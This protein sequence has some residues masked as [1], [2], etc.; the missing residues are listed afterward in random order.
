MTVSRT[1]RTGILRVSNPFSPS[2]IYGP[3]HTTGNDWLIQHSA[4][5]HIDK[6]TELKQGNVPM[7]QPAVAIHRA[8]TFPC[9]FST[10]DSC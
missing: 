1:V 8:I 2:T 5:G 3:T 7:Q 10:F 4:E 6:I 9:V